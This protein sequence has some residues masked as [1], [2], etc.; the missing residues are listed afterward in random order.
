LPH[1]DR[2]ALRRWLP[3]GRVDQKREDALA[4]LDAIAA[5]LAQGVPAEPRCEFEP[6]FLWQKAVAGWSRPSEPAGPPAER[7]LPRR[8]TLAGLLGGDDISWRP[9]SERSGR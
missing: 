1:A 5:F 4:M 8:E 6:T 9:G 3:G 7:R 2:E